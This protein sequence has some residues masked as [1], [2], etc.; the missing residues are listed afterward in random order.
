MIACDFSETVT[1]VPRR[2]RGKDLTE[3]TPFPIK[4]LDAKQ[5]RK[6]M[7]IGHRV[8][9]GVVQLCN[10]DVEYEA[11]RVGIGVPWPNFKD[12][13][14]NVVQPKTVKDGKHEVLSEESID[15]ISKVIGELAA[16]VIR[17]NKLDDNTEDDE[18]GNAPGLTLS[19]SPSSP[20]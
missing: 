2:D 15:L 13:R 8:I 3:Q 12:K 1:Y 18:Q 17:V 6:I 10:G 9:G 16:E 19:S 14:G 11:V 20:N 4:I 5:R 7:N